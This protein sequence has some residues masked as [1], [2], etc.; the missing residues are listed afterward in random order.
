MRTHG[1]VKGKNMRAQQKLFDADDH[2]VRVMDAVRGFM[3]KAKKSNV[4]K[5]VLEIKSFQKKGVNT[6]FSLAKHSE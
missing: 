4:T 5:V 2:K 6:H 1:G 3:M